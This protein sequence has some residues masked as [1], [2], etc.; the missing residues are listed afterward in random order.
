MLEVHCF[1]LDN[2][3]MFKGNFF[4]VHVS[5][6]PLTKLDTSEVAISS[7]LSLTRFDD[8]SS[9]FSSL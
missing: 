7:D 9:G 2:K 6:I 8:L 3:G 5:L 4:V 1:S